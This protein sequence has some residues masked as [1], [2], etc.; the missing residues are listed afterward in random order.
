VPREQDFLRHRVRQHVASALQQVTGPINPAEYGPCVW[1][2][3]PRDEKA[4]LLDLAAELVGA[5]FTNEV[6][7]QTRGQSVDTG[8]IDMFPLDQWI[9]AAESGKR[10]RYRHAKWDDHRAHRENQIM[11]VRAVTRAFDAEEGRRDR[12]AALGM[13][14]NPD[15]TTE[16]ALRLGE[17][18][19]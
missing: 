11:N 13:A 5:V 12:L 19:A 15:M 2:R 1:Q 16:E 3:L 7:E 4:E 6:K 14:D 8:D 10:V 17:E 9:G 18:A